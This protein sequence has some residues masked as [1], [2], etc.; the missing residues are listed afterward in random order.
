VPDAREPVG[1]E[2]WL[3]AEAPR[4]APLPPFKEA[5]AELLLSLGPLRATSDGPDLAPALQLLLY[6]LTEAE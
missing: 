2:P 1:V 4:Q 6:R 3:G 5:P